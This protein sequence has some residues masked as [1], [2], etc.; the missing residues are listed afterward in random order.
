M[1]HAQHRSDEMV[2][3]VAAG[4]TRVSCNGGGG[5]L[6]H[7]LIWLTLTASDDG[8]AK[9][10]TCPYCSRQFIQQQEA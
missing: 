9:S 8:D 10:A 2:S 4:V 6:G 1:S 7:P 5:A 3:P